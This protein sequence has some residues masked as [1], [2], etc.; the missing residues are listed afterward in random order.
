MISQTCNSWDWTVILISYSIIRIRAGDTLYHLE[1]GSFYVTRSVLLSSLAEP[2]AKE[3]IRSLKIIE[4]KNWRRDMLSLTII[5]EAFDSKGIAFLLI[6][7]HD[8][9]LSY[10][11]PSKPI[12]WHFIIEVLS[13]SS[14]QDSI[15]TLVSKRVINSSN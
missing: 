1:G 3:A 12:A 5:K 15:I 11:L 13:Q 4:W 8:L 7:W 2:M 9:A 6:N 14:W 10:C